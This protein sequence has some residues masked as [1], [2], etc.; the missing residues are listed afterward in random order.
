MILNKKILLFILLVTPL[1]IQAQPDQYRTV[2]TSRFT[3]KPGG[4]VEYNT[5]QKYGLTGSL[6]FGTFK[7]Q[8]AVD[9]DGKPAP[10]GPPRSSF[11]GLALEGHYA[12]GGYRAVLR[13][14]D[15]YSF[16]GPAGL[17]LGAAYYSNNSYSSVFK[18]RE[19]IGIE[20][21]LY[22]VFKVKAG[23]LKDLDENRWIP[24]LGFGIPFGPK[25]YEY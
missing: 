11:K 15:L 24:T 19:L 13:F 14:Y 23:I 12:R 2:Y 6:F 18:R 4:A 5:P 25:M 10:I 21:E 1:T 17:T 16:V 3:L 9:A 22:L 7:N 20:G 8:T